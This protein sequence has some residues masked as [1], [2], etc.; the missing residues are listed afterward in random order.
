VVGSRKCGDEPS[1]SNATELA[2]WHL[3]YVLP[4]FIHFIFIVLILCTLIF[5]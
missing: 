4:D 3:P 5:I 2:R 1:G